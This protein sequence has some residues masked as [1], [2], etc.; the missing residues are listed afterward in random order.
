M[1]I[2]REVFELAQ[3]LEGVEEAEGV[4]AVILRLLVCVDKE[5]GGKVKVGCRTGLGGVSAPPGPL[6][7][8][9]F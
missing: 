5:V 1:A 4:F 8:G 6:I 9:L 3:G 2:E 7:H